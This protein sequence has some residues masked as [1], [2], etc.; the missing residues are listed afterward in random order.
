MQSFLFS[1][2][3]NNF[4]SG[5]KRMAKQKYYVVWVGHK[6]GVYSDWE[7][8]KL[9]IAGF[10]NAVYKSFESN[11]LAEQAFRQPSA[12]HI[13]MIEA[14][15]EP[16]KNVMRNV[17]QPIA[18]S[19]S[20]D[21]AWNTMSGAAEYQGVHTSTKELVFKK[22]PFENGT[23]NIVEF[24][25]LVHALAYCKKNN[26]SVPVY[27]DSK[28]AISW[29]KNKKA[30]T[31]HSQ[32]SKNKEL[33]DLIERAEKWLHQNTYSTPILK[34]ETRAWGENPADFGRK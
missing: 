7:S 19:I 18:N 17:G 23:N 8:C 14:T 9:Q 29:V 6:P 28:T 26:L 33:F 4:F 31:Q 21:G 15:G 20:V 1:L 22:G 5:L 11:I 30:K 16:I 32:N 13:G 3:E 24:L 27:S 34:W 25:A 12:M 2:T 10:P